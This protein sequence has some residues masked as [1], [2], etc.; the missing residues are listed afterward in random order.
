MFIHRGLHVMSGFFLKEW[1]PILP[2]YIS[3]PPNIHSSIALTDWNATLQQWSYTAAHVERKEDVLH[4][5]V[6]NFIRTI[7]FNSIANEFII[8]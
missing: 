6:F 1:A 4:Y 2:R 7:S 8:A 3:N 5:L